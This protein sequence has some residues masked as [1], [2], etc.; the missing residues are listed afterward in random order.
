MTRTAAIIAL[1]LALGLSAC[2][3]VRSARD[4]LVRTSSSCVDQTVPIY[5]ETGVAEVPADGRRVLQDAAARARG[6]TVKSVSV[7][8]LADAPGAPQA[9]LDL[10]R[11][12]VQAVAAIL[13]SLGLPAADFDAAAV[14]AAGAVTP[15]GRADP[16]RR[17]AEITL[18]LEPRK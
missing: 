17:R 6:C 12:R 18:R 10:S 3:T 15:D 14:G 11:R 2:Q 16:L 9:N 1:A 8:G 7:I 4:R 13:G 5:F